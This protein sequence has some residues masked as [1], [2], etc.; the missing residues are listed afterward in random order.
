VCGIAGKVDGAGPVDRGLV[1]AMCASICH[2]GPDS[3]GDHLD[4]GV[5]LAIRR[6]AII[7]L[8]TAERSSV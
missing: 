3:R 8:V 7:D 4:G 6:L 2:R 5:A 1:D